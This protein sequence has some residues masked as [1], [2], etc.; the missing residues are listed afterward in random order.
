MNSLDLVP[1][2][3]FFEE[4]E[5]YSSLKQKAVTKTDYESSKYL[6]ENLKMRNLSDMNDLYNMQDVILLLQIIENRSEEMYKKYLYNPRKCNSAS[7]LSGCIQRYLS[8][9]I[10][11]LPT[12]N[13][14]VEVFEK[15]LTEG[16]SSVNTRL[17]FDTEILLPN[18]KQTD[19]NKMSIDK[20]FHS[21]KN[22]DFKVYKLKM[23]KGTK[24]V[25]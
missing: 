22:Q 9:V 19:Y 24:I 25:E 16:F 11:A 13:D 17:G 7:T 10:L 1:E 2:K 6:F 14:H 5:F 4:S 20:K 12:S 15:T 23:K 18:L 8:K 3:D 21:F